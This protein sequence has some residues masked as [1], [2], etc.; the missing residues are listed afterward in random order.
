M[1][2]LGRVRLVV[3][4][5]AFT[6]LGA[7]SAPPSPECPDGTVQDAE[8]EACVAAR[9]G[10]GAWGSIDRNSATVHVAP[11]G[12]DSGDGSEERPYETIQRG[13]DAAGEVGGELV[14]VAAGTFAE[15]LVLTAG[16]D[17]VSIEGRCVDL[18]VLDASDEEESRGVQ[19]VGA[20]IALRGLTV[21]GGMRGIEI[22]ATAPGTATLAA[23]DVLFDRNVAV[24]LLV[25]ARSA[26]DLEDVTVRDTQLLPDGSVGTGIHLQGGTLFARNP[27]LERN[28]TNG[29][30]V[31]SDSVAELEDSTIR[32]TEARGDGT[33]GM[34]IAVSSG[35]QLIGR[36]LLVDGNT[37]A[38]LIA[39][40]TGIVDLQDSTIR[41]TRP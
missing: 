36:R 30:S 7:C 28:R 15:A 33:Q 14:A 40:P 25:F 16:H 18:V 24:G 41:G 1:G 13:V 31:S 29:L 32:G 23:R 11:W 38:G 3:A 19:I 4:A 10:T 2:V 6:L 20:D 37:T 22:N 5:A 27:L 34:G 39:A 9:C 8:T 21:T 26:V 17:D 35:G 12:D